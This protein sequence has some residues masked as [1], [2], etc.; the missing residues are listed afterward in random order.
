M[1][2][3]C[4]TR[5]TL[6]PAVTKALHDTISSLTTTDA[7]AYSEH[8]VRINAVLTGPMEDPDIPAEV[9]QMM[10]GRGGAAGRGLGGRLR[11]VEEVVDSVV[12]L[13]GEKSSFLHGQVLGR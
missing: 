2:S 5:L 7:T 6:I 12:W 10:A 13:L 11:T 1:G 8:L 3:H 9:R 4:A